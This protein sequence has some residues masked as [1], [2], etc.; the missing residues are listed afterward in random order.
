[1]KSICIFAGSSFG[2]DFEYVEKARELGKIMAENGF[3]IVYGGSKN[4]L[5]GEI[6]NEVLSHDGEV[7]GIMPRG[8][9]K[10]EN[11]H[12][13]LTKLIEVDTMHERKAK[14]SE[15]ADGY[16]ALPGGLGTFEELFEVLCW[17]QIGIHHKPIGVLNV[18]GYYD[19][20]LN[21]INHCI[22]KGFS[23]EIHKSI[24]SSSSDPETLLS[25][26][27]NYVP[28]EIEYKWNHQNVSLKKEK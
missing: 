12:S 19:P 23:G 26:M 2:N 17:A 18:N 27:V 24:I 28:K 8:L 11:V 10:G 4:G 16:I 7:V 25:L 3:S 5:M 15:L 22:Q 9:I 1:M 20:L 6:A 13:Q 14:M 21:L